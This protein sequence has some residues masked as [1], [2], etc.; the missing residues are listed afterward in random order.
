MTT[1]PTARAMALV[2][3]LTKAEGVSDDLR[4]RAIKLIAEV[5]PETLDPNF[6]PLTAIVKLAKLLEAKTKATVTP[7]NTANK[8]CLVK[9]TKMTPVELLTFI[10]EDR[11]NAKARGEPEPW[12]GV[13]EYFAREKEAETK[14][15]KDISDMVDETNRSF[16]E[17]LGQLVLDTVPHG[18]EAAVKIIRNDGGVFIQKLDNDEAEPATET[19]KPEATMPNA[20]E[21]FDALSKAID[22]TISSFAERGFNSLQAHE[23]ILAVVDFKQN[24]RK[25]TSYAN[26]LNRDP[27]SGA[28]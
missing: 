7:A 1:N 8:G 27:L 24:E 23:Y 6:D 17:G 25:M 9:L 28:E 4:A 20:D 22:D 21:R 16:C 26:W 14:K 5:A 11:D 13:K 12:K 3:E 15:P 19:P 10:E 2:H 18:E